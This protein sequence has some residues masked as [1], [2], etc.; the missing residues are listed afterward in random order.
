MDVRPCAAARFYSVSQPSSSRAIPCRDPA[1]GGYLGWC[2]S[3]LRDDA[4]CV[5]VAAL[6]SPVTGGCVDLVHR[7]F[8]AARA[9]PGCVAPSGGQRACG[10]R[11]RVR[12]A[13]HLPVARPATSTAARHL[14]PTFCPTDW[15]PKVPCPPRARAR[16]GLSYILTL[17][18]SCML[19]AW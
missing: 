17:H 19:A 10:P 14:L 16:Q 13:R 12:W 18:G 8:E 3:P 15:P 4:A 11:T 1:E 2:N 6:R 9:G 5:P 7:P